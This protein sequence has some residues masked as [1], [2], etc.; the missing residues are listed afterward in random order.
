MRKADGLK[1]S[2]EFDTLFAEVSAADGRHVEENLSKMARIL[3]EQQDLEIQ[4]SMAVSLHDPV[5][6]KKKMCCW[7][8][9]IR[10]DQNFFVTIDFVH[11][12]SNHS[13]SL[14][15]EYV[16]YSGNADL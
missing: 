2:S 11:K 4:K 5:K 8:K 15:N 9:Y 3:L 1:L 10:I 16:L 12:S 6:K 13:R 7:M 14:I